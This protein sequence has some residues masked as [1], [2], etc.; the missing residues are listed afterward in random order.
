LYIP[1][2]NSIE[3]KKESAAP[4]DSFLGSYGGKVD[5][6]WMSHFD[7]KALMGKRYPRQGWDR[8]W[9]G[10]E[11]GMHRQVIKTVFLSQKYLDS[12][13]WFL[14]P[15]HPH[16]S[17]P[18]HFHLFHPKLSPFTLVAFS[19]NVVLGSYLNV[20]L[21]K[22]NL[23]KSPSQQKQIWCETFSMRVGKKLSFVQNRK[24]LIDLF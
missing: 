9:R 19:F 22:L 8:G 10:H 14:C 1:G 5:C 3:V 12:L 2:P 21:P 16:S 20:V 6:S 18:H 13:R 15:Q 24:K 17:P 23:S 11:D 7:R 4:S